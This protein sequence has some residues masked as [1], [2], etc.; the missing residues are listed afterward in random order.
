MMDHHLNPFT[1]T[2]ISDNSGST[3]SSTAQI[4][5][6]ESLNSARVECLAGNLPTSSQVG[7]I[8]IR[9]IGKQE[10]HYSFLCGPEILLPLCRLLICA[11]N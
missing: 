9:V 8:T 4:V 5:A 11:H 7:N 10:I 1:I 3:L 6:T 2:M